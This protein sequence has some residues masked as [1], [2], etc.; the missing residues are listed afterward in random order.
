MSEIVK[1]YNPANAA[2]L[3]DQQLNDLR[4]LTTEQLRDLAKAYPN[5]TF[6]RG[7]LMIVDGSKPIQNQLPALSTF[8]NLYN[9]RTKNGLSKYIAIGFKGNYQKTGVITPKKGKVEVLDLSDT[10]LL[11]VPGFKT[12]VGTNREES[13]PEETVKVTKIEKEVIQPETVKTDQP[14]RTRRT[15]AQIEADKKKNK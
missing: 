6:N 7:Y 10:E 1:T 11:T 15:K 4:N 13:F 3:N 5:G 8:Q 12:G 14:K 2:S 9:L